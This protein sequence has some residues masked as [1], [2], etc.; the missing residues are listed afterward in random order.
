MTKTAAR[1]ARGPKIEPP[2]CSACGLPARLTD[3]KEIYPHRPDLHAKKIWVCDSCNGYVGCH[4]DTA[5]PLGTPAH[6]T[7]RDARMILHERLVDPLWMEADRQLG[8]YEPESD[9][10]RMVIRQTARGRVYQYLAVQLGIDRSEC[11]IAMFDL[12]TCR[13]AWTALKGV[14]YPQIRDWYKSTY[15]K[16]DKAA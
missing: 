6:R 10:A 9:K 16:K 1:K 4:G 3:G 14:T 7:L 12:A 11:H 8:L 5:R 13:R 15:P 2:I